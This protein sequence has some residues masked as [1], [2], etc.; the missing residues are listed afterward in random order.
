M[1]SRNAVFTYS[2]LLLLLAGPATASDAY[3]VRF[4]ATK[5]ASPCSLVTWQDGALFFNRSFAPA[6]VRVIGIS[7]GTP[8][9]T[10]PDSFVVPAG[11]TISLPS[12]LA[13][14]WLPMPFEPSYTLWVMHLDVPAGVTVASHDDLYVTDAC[15]SGHQR[16]PIGGTPLPVFNALVHAGI[17][18]VHL[19]TDV[20][21][22]GSRTNVGVYNAADTAATATLQV[23]RVCDDVVMDERIVVIPPNSAVQIGALGRGTDD[24]A[25]DPQSVRWMRYTTV[26]VDRPSLSWV[27]NVTEQSTGYEGIAPRIDVSIAH[28]T[29]Y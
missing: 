9:E 26:T 16:L 24:C 11:K 15:L 22:R 18:Q 14:V 10:M 20:G 4:T 3:I 25:S 7:N 5:L 6:T 19:R 17:T 29:N 1:S 13:G 28:S 8:N 12:A 23:R 21:S 2:V 27:S